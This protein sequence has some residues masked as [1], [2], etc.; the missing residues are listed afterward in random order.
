MF[1]CSAISLLEGPSCNVRSLR[2]LKEI[3]VDTSVPEAAYQELNIDTTRGKG[4]EYSI[5]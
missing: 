5:M 3:Y 2:M 1:S 4:T